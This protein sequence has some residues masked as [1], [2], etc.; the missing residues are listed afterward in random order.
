MASVAQRDWWEQPTREAFM[1]AHQRELARLIEDRD[2]MR[3]VDIAQAYAARARGES[4][5][6]RTIYPQAGSAWTVRA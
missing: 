5:T 4:L 2:G 1:A 3:L 6:R